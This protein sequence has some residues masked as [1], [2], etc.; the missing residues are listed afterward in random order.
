MLGYVQ[1]G[2]VRSAA[3]SDPRGGAG[4]KRQAAQPE[5]SKQAQ[6]PDA[7][8]TFRE[9]L[10]YLFNVLENVTSDADLR[11]VI[12]CS[13]LFDQIKDLFTDS[14]DQS[15]KT[16]LINIMFNLNFKMPEP[17]Q[18][19]F[20]F[21]KLLH[22]AYSEGLEG[23]PQ[24]GSARRENVAQ[25]K[26]VSIVV[27]ASALESNH[28]PI[29]KSN[30]YT[31]FKRNINDDY[32]SMAANNEEIE[33]FGLVNIALNKH[34]M[35]KIYMDLKKIH[36]IAIKNDKIDF[37]TKVDLFVEVSKYVAKISNKQKLA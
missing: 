10:K 37:K 2:P 22:K 30:F 27:V 28:D 7:V 8:Q 32:A 24:L 23:P 9:T 29:I 15:N 6:Q 5:E 26:M 36:K 19:Q 21:L 35:D 3:D 11:E 18:L 4:D 25:R 20:D 14:L 12:D 16:S 34:K 1:N 33:L 17:A 13:K 31:Q